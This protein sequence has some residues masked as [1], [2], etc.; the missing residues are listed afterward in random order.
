MKEKV[1]KE[2][3]SVV[4]PDE[5]RAKAQIL[6]TTKTMADIQLQSFLEGCMAGLGLEGDWNL[7]TNTWTFTQMPEKPQEEGK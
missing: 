7:D 3:K 6:A 5:A 2:L 1:I 4:M